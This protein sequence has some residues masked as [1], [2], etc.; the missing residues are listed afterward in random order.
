MLVL[1]KEEKFLSLIFL[2]GL[3]IFAVL[4]FHNFEYTLRG[5]HKVRQADTLFSGYSYCFED[6]SFLKP[7]IA[8]RENTTGIAIGE[9]PLF[10]YLLSIPCKLTGRW[11]ESFPRILSLLFFALNAVLWGL[12]IRKR[13]PAVSMSAWLIFFCFSSLHLGHL[14]IP[15]PD[16]L[17]LLFVGGAL[18]L[19]DR[20]DKNFWMN[21][22]GVLLFVLGFWMRPYLFP[23]LFFKLENRK[24]VLSTFIACVGIYLFW[25]K[26]WVIKNSEIE[27]YYT[28]L[29]HFSD[30]IIQAPSL[31]GP[32]ILIA[33][34]EMTNYIGIFMI[35]FF[36]RDLKK[37]WLLWGVI[38]LMV[39]GARGL[40]MLNHHYYLLAASVVTSIM[41]TVAWTQ[42]Q[43][44]YKLWIPI[45]FIISGLS[46]NQH[47]WNPP[48][49]KWQM[50]LE[51]M[52][53][54]QVPKDAKVATYIGLSPQWLYL[55]KRTGW[56]FDPKKY[57]GTCPEGATW[58]LILVN[59]NPQFV[60]CSASA[61]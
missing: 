4:Y 36:A 51:G 38:W 45:L 1:K 29:G 46:I 25:Y 3:L 21:L 32:Y 18:L 60:R 31:I 61:L 10:S 41:M 27:Y 2:F 11:S 58:A 30:W 8:H 49:E 59:E 34:K 14:T 13:Y 19:W 16:G 15:L 9:L 50:Q 28:N 42:M 40:H 6:T 54:E 53:D 56:M 55:I 57:T 17:A 47:L 7:R 37:L 26:Y 33:G 5:I 24:L 22:L 43:N 39:I 12:W 52:A 20:E 48:R 35:L 23:L 44:R